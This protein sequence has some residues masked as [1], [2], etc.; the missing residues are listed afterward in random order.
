[1]CAADVATLKPIGSRR[2]QLISAGKEEEETKLL[3]F[4]LK[5]FGAVHRC[6]GPQM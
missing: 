2:Q 6:A 4:F 3:N 5:L 1:M